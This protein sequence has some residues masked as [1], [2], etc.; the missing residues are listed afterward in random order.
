MKNFWKNEDGVT[1]VEWVVLIAAIVGVT[2]VI[3]SLLAPTI[4]NVAERNA[5]VLD[6]NHSSQTGNGG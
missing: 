4:G 5:N 3:L 1:Q 6:K 2:I